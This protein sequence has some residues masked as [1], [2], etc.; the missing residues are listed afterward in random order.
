MGGVYSRKDLRDRARLSI[1]G[2]ANPAMKSPFPALC[3]ARAHDRD[4]EMW[5]A[6]AAYQLSMQ[7]GPQGRRYLEESC[8]ILQRCASYN[9]YCRADLRSSGPLGCLSTPVGE[10]G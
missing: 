10:H 5:G 8:S 4:F 1:S 6:R 2:D 9:S 7:G 3:L